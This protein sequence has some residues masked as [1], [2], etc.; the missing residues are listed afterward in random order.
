MCAYERPQA[1]AEDAVGRFLGD[2]AR[3]RPRPHA[4]LAIA[5]HDAATRE[6]TH[7][8]ELGHRRD[9]AWGG[10]T[11]ASLAVDLGAQ[12]R[13]DRFGT[14]VPFG[15]RRERADPLLAAA[16]LDRPEVLHP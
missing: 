11:A 2:L 14:L 16:V 9:H 12:L 3:M 13:L 10:R 5:R 8:G 7:A 4:R 6:H 1:L 15:A